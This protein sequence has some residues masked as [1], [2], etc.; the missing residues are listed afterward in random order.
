ML[1]RLP[2][3]LSLGVSCAAAQSLED[4]LTGNPDLTSLVNALEEFP[5]LLDELNSA[6]N[7]TV[8]APNNAAF[9]ALAATPA[10]QAAASDPSLLEAVLEYHVI[11][12][13]YLACDIPATGAFVPTLLTNTSYTNVTGGQRVEGVNQNG[14]V[15]FFSGGKAQS[16][17]TQADITFNGGVVHI[18][19]SVLTIPANI[20]ATAEAAGLTALANALIQTNL[21]ETV[22][23]LPDI[24]VF[25]P[26]NAAFA[27][28]N[29][30]VASL[31][32]TQ[33]ARVLE[34]HVIN[35]TVGYSTLLTNG[36]TISTLDN[37][38]DVTITLPGNGSVKVNQANV[39]IPDVLVANG[40]V[41]VIDSV[42]IPI[43]S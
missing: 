18:I 24:T 10:G 9:A 23:I 36:E 6:Q 43:C 8:L 39:V 32:N 25:A 22:N 42:L 28:I 7:I 19:D 40:V 29:G 13:T 26:T 1:F 41:H 27:A 35:G 2:L 21:L 31:T 16:N 14:N 4:V 33:L 12:G 38:L 20:T 3:L 34:Y 15:T 11:N 37:G 5:A 30:T 17:V